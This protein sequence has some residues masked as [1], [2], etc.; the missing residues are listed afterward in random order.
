[1]KKL[2]PFVLCAVL[3]FALAACSGG[4][5]TS[6]GGEAS[7]APSESQESTQQAQSA[8]TQPEETEPEAGGT[9]IA[10]FA[11]SGNT[12]AMADVYKRQC[13]G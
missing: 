4:N 1:M 5:G 12:E 2:L 3:L 11:W 13:W 8:D 6:A 7:P 9:L 10:Y